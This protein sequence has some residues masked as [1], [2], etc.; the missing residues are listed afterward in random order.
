MQRKRLFEPILIRDLEIKN[1]ILM[2]PI[3]LTNLYPPNEGT[4]PQRV[5]DYYVE[6]AKGGVGLI[7]TGVFKVENEVENYQ[8][9][10]V[11]IWQVL[12]P[13]ALPGLAELADQVHN[14]GAK[15]FLQL[16]AGPGRVA[17][18]DVIDAGFT[19][20]SASPNPAFYRPNVTCR[21]LTTKEV[22]KIVEA[23]GRVTQ[24]VANVGVD[25]VEVHGHEGY[26][27]D[28]F[29]T[30]LWNKRRD[31]YGGDLRGR[32]S[33]AIEILKQ[34]RKKAGEDFP[35]TIRLGIKHFIKEPWKSSLR[36]EG[37]VEAGRDVAESIEAAKILEEAGYDA[38]H[39]DA[40]CYDSFY[41]AHPPTYQPDACTIDLI[42]GVKKVV[43][44]PV[45]TANKLGNPK[46][47]EEILRE[48]KADMIALGR[49][50][51][52]DP[53]WPNKVREDR[54]EDIRPCIGCHEGCLRLPAVQSK[55]TS[56]SVNP[57]CGREKTYLLTKSNRLKKI[58]VIGGGVAGMEAARMGTQRGHHVVLYEKSD[59]LGGHL[60]EACVP[61]FKKD[62]KNLLNWYERQ[63]IKLGIEI[64]VNTE[65]TPNLIPGL[66]F[67]AVVL[68]TG[69]VPSVPSIPGMER[70]SVTNCCEV[71]SGKKEVG[72]R[73]VL[74]GGG[75]E[76]C[77]TAIWLAQKGKFV[78]IVEMLDDVA[79]GIHSANRQMLLDMMEDLSIRI[80]RERTICEVFDNG[81]SFVDKSLNKQFMECNDLI[82]GV[83]L[84]P[85]RE[86]Y[87]TLRNEVQVFYEI[88]DCKIPRNLHYAI[89]E[90]FNVGYSI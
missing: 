30:F 53:Q 19:P 81:I 83:G 73:V 90:G 71:L 28:Q 26:L 88:G 17:R 56:C 47:A 20:V 41:W 5:I 1:R 80:L 77:E 63:I 38:L 31:K 13:N 36:P 76:G 24:M 58:L 55:P 10:G 60:R 2:A 89:L 69:S 32:L 74:L 49:P 64:H 66:D 46:I 87:K 3:N 79:T 82:L 62:L 43:R 21:E 57:S 86:L 16:S 75:L 85:V 70:S 12:T 25:G 37:F 9:D 39:I 68:A 40:G 42:K 34:I 72:H 8:K 33:F 11:R 6:R 51:L 52:A 23:F 84:K 4:V 65:V 18:G 61:E 27:I 44:I 7:V 22:E 67:D 59:H 35:V 14:F 29:N 78:C 48:N 15:L 50:L 54:E 45:L